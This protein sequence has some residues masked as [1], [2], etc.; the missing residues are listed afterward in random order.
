MSQNLF[1]LPF[2]NR[3]IFFKFH[4]KNVNVFLFSYFEPNLIE[5]F[6][7]DSWFFFFNFFSF[8]D[9]YFETEHFLN[10][11]FADLWLFLVY[12]DMV[13]VSYQK[14]LRKST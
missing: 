2:V 7:W 13:Q 12:T 4:F 3:I 10:V 6:L 5:K 9:R 8:F 11:L 1:W 14:F